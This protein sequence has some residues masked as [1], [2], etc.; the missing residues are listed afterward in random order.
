MADRKAVR[1]KAA[2]DKMGAAPPGAM[3]ESQSVGR[4]RCRDEYPGRSD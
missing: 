1:W 4:H 2:T 3:T